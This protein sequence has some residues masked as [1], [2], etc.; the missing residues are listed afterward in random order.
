MFLHVCYMWDFQH[1]SIKSKIIH[2]IK[3]IV[4][5]YND[6]VCLLIIDV[7]IITYCYPL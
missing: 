6:N 1:H 4:V 5:N 2:H 7:S 3:Y